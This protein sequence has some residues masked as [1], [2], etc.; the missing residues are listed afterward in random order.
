MNCLT[1]Y[2]FLPAASH[3]NERA[4]RAASLGYAAIA[5]ADRHFLARVVRAC[6]A[7]KP[8]NV[9]KMS[10]LTRIRMRVKITWC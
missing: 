8:L 4:H 5:S 3:P 10:N 2:L 9:E 6:V 7:A 1:N